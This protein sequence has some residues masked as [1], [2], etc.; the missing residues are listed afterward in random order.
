MRNH[1]IR[2]CRTPKVV[3]KCFRETR[4]AR[5]WR[6]TRL[7]QTDTVNI[8]LGRAHANTLSTQHA[9]SREADIA[10]AACIARFRAARPLAVGIGPVGQPVTVIVRAVIADCFRAALAI[11]IRAVGQPVAV[12]VDR[13]VAGQFGARLVGVDQRRLERAVVARVSEPVAICDL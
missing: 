8:A 2:L 1:P 13:I 6:A 5:A 7:R 12:V 11:R 3:L 4:P 9:A 10:V